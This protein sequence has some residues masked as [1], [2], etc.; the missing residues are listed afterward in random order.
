MAEDG[1]LFIDKY[2]DQTI[3]KA[4]VDGHYYPL[5][6]PMPAF[7]VLPV[8]KVLNS[9]GLTKSYEADNGNSIFLLGS[10]LMGSLP[11]AL[12]ITLL[13]HIILSS[14]KS[15]WQAVVI[16]MLSL[17]GSMYFIYTGIFYSHI[18]V[19]FSIA[20]SYFWI[21]KSKNFFFAGLIS[22]LAFFSEY[23]VAVIFA[24]WF[25][26]IYFSKPKGAILYGLGLLPSIL[27]FLAYNYA[28][29][30]HPLLTVYSFNTA[31][32]MEVVGFTYPK[33]TALFQ[34][35]FS[36]WRGVLIFIPV[37]W[38]IFYAIKWTS[39]I[40]L[41]NLL[42]SNLWMPIIVF[43][44]LL[45]SYQ[46]WHGGW[47]FGPRYLLPATTLFIIGF[48]SQ[49]QLDGRKK[50]WFYIPV[51]IG[52]IYTFLDKITVMYSI[53]SASKFPFIQTIWPALKEGRINEGN[54]LSY[55]FNVSPIIAAMIWLLLFAVGFYLM[56]RISKNKSE[57]L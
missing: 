52:F 28:A 33:I 38:S 11:L 14:G 39:W 43:V 5:Q 51:G 48:A 44:L 40:G 17:Y 30:G 1:H 22:G 54:V 53:P 42:K 56:M 6:P 12:L 9:I 46:E 23:L 55:L 41:K 26:Q 19:S 37:L 20:L 27:G 8:Y 36:P 45:M 13:F 57:I 4:Y 50:Y 49:I 24:I 18:F 16:S 21:S 15:R 10:F 29:T 31:Y 47:T 35:I 3:D 7:M 25:F 2:E 32:D 34:M